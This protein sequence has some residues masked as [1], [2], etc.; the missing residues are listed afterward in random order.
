MLSLNF[1]LTERQIRLD[2]F[3]MF[4][5]SVKGLNL[6]F[7]RNL[8]HVHRHFLRYK[9]TLTYILCIYVFIFPDPPTGP[10]WL[11]AY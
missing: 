8:I 2:R 9:T 3:K 5:T 10:L 7:S 11:I 1:A 6:V 4:L